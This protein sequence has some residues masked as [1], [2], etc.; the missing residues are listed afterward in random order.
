MGFDVKFGVGQSVKRKE[1]IRFTTG[2]GRYIDD[3]V[4]PDQSFG[5]VVRSPVAKGEIKS[6]DVDDARA[7]DGVLAVLTASDMIAEN[8][9]AMAVPTFSTPRVKA[10]GQ[11]IPRPALASTRVCYVGEPIVFIVADT[12][13]TAEDAAELVMIDID[14]EDVVSSL[15]A[16]LAVD[17]PSVH[18]DQDG[19]KGFVWQ[20]GDDE[21]IK[22]AFA[23]AAHTISL[24][25]VNNRVAPSAMEPRG[26]NCCFHK[27]TGVMDV[28]TFSQGAWSI[29]GELA[30][31][32]LNIER[33]KVNILTSDVG[34]GFG[35][36]G[37][38]YPEHYLTSIAARK[39]GRP[40]K[41]NATRN[42]SFLSDSH[43]RGHLTTVSLAFDAD[44]RIVAMDVK[45]DADMGAY[46]ST[47]GPYIPTEAA[48]QILPGVY[49]IP[50]LRYRVNGVLTN[51]VPV[52]AYRGAGRPESIFAL[53]R[54]MTFAAC[55]LGLDPVE[56]RRINFIRP[57]QL[58][59]TTQVDKSYDSGKFEHV[60][61]M[62]LEQSDAKRFAN[63][64]K[65][66]ENRGRRLGFGMAYYIESTLGNPYEAAG[67]YF[68]ENGDLECTVGTQSNGQGHE[69]V[70]AQVLHEQ[71]GYDFDKIKIVQSDTRRQ[72]K[73]NG[74]GGSRSLIAQGLALNAVS[75]N[76]IEKARSHAA[77]QLECSGADLEIEHGKFTV[78]GTDLAITIQELVT[79]LPAGTL[80]AKGEHSDYASTY[81]NGCHVAEVEVDPLTGHAQTVSYFI[82]DDFGVLFNPMVVE[83]QVHGGV[84]QGI[85]Q[86]FHENMV[87]DENGQPVTGSFMDYQMP[88]ASDFPQFHFHHEG[89]PAKTNVMGVK[90]CGEAGTVAAPAAVMNALVD[91]LAS[92]GVKHIDMPA[93]PLAVWQALQQVAV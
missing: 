74:T 87:Y 56:L 40:V 85:G 28:H 36:K 79:R 62:V 27:D 32:C 19:N 13:Q 50:V 71:L 20:L 10:G 31:N 29:Q 70:Y 12:L 80:D 90:G 44:Y 78:A 8:A 46:Y 53:E 61:D 41:W 30:K 88:R 16:A 66:A 43:G 11:A 77:E 42:E 49:D 68:M 59:Y 18:P 7:A 73:G 64:R 25:L 5:V 45:T 54:T 92:D 15:T 33:D 83:G 47:F 67:I 4:L 35:M 60:M 76:V 38:T 86:A 23:S 65:E 26:V 1:D 72:K 57:D 34:G 37:F 89:D 58:P 84:V 52:D 17:A 9:N 39:L 6:V 2:N 91:A 22:T 48:M 51:T 24:D 21:P 14:D 82:V 63:R 81:P 75:D 69:T 3:I 55:E 93:T